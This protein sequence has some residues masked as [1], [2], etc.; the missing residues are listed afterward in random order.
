MSDRIRHL[1]LSHADYPQGESQ[2]AAL[3]VRPHELDIVSEPDGAS[4]LQARV[5][6]INPIGAYIRVQLR[7]TSSDAEVN[8]DISPRRYAE[9]ELVKGQHVFVTPQ[10][11]RVF[12]EPVLDYAI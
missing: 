1:E 4:S 10:R 5:V 9:L 3:Y 12:A 11:I 2:P 6:H 8:V 7:L